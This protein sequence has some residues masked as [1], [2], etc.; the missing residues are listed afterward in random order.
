MP[1]P[2]ITQCP[3]HRLK[4]SMVSNE[5]SLFCSHQGKYKNKTLNFKNMDNRF[6]IFSLNTAQCMGSLAFLPS[7]TPCCCSLV[8]GLSRAGGE[9]PALSILMLCTG[10]GAEVLPCAEGLP[11]S[12][13]QVQI[14]I[15]FRDSLA[16]RL[17]THATSSPDTL[18]DAAVTQNQPSQ[19]AL[20][21]RWE[22]GGPASEQRKQ[23]SPLS[24]VPFPTSS[25]SAARHQALC[26]EQN[27]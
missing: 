25:A 16:P 22:S 24:L 20:K 11:C 8:L 3:R 10:P 26:Q 27:S 19:S 21:R 15:S 17:E 6:K 23:T 9:R 13:L 5:S 18:S 12:G 14:L 7:L 4:G 1:R 2:S